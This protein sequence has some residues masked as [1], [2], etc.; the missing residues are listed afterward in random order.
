MTPDQVTCNNIVRQVTH[1]FFMVL[2]AFGLQDML[3]SMEEQ[4]EACFVL[5]VLQFL[6]YLYGTALHLWFEHEADGCKKNSIGVLA[7]RQAFVVMF[8]IAGVYV[9]QAES[10]VQ[11]IPRLAVI[12]ALSIVWGLID[13]AL[14]VRHADPQGAWCFGLPNG[15]QFA[16]ALVAG[17]LYDGL[18][19]TA[20]LPF[21]GWS[22][23]LV[24][25]AGI[26]AAALY[27]DFRQMCLTVRSARGLPAGCPPALPGRSQA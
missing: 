24:A 20:E 2:L 26:Y 11:F 1:A 18:E 14:A 5:A 13:K 10:A 15:L 7:W 22:Y 21:V 3:E 4:R 6:R 12:P 19:W 16:G 9:C 27:L 25:L 17:L 23:V 8:G